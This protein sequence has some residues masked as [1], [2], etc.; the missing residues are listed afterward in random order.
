MKWLTEIIAGLMILCPSLL[1]AQD[2][3][4]LI[5]YQGRLTDGA[6]HPIS[7]NVNIRV[8][9]YT[10]ITAGTFLYQ[11][12]MGTLP[13]NN[14]IFHLQFGSNAEELANALSHPEAWLEINV[15]GTPLS[16]RNRLVAVPYA[17]SAGRVTGRVVLGNETNATPAAGSLRWT[18][19]V[20]EGYT[21]S[22]WIA[23]SAPQP[24]V[25][26]EMVEIGFAGNEEDPS[27]N[28]MD[29]NSG[30]V[31]YSYEIGKYEVTNDEYTTFLNAV[32]PNGINGLG[33]YSSSMNTD[34]Q[35]GGI[36]FTASNPDGAKYTV[37][38]DFG[39]KPVVYVNFYDA[40]R[41]CNWLHNGALLGADTETGA[42]TLLGNVE[43]PTNGNTLFR[44]P[45][46]KWALP[47]ENEWYK[48]AYFQPA[49]A[50]GDS[51]NYWAW[52]TRSNTTPDGG[53]PPG[54]FPAANYNDDGPIPD[55]LTTVG[56]YTSTPGYFGTF[57]MA[58]NANEWLETLYE[59]GNNRIIRSGSWL[60]DIYAMPSGLP[61]EGTPSWGDPTSGFRVVRP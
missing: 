8:E 55:R 56:A 5:N 37:K 30:A 58:G 12:D 27:D 1:L 31:A 44:N 18:G 25:R 51:D 45:G 3:P 40:I 39:N 16:P 57:D 13:V 10:N 41:F 26:T 48:A 24:L 46:A 21:G 29:G 17:L 52:P 20:F 42:Y 36:T 28:G 14:G 9:I 32:D 53:S 22:E 15:N 7:S 60:G 11:E 38:T 23:L 6:G 19:S 54:I 34:V 50:G 47:S 59:S 43:I 4:S 35:N 49:S 33:L 2:V 61:G